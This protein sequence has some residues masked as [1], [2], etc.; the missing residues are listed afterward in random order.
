MLVVASFV[1]EL[2]KRMLVMG[3]LVA[4]F[5]GGSFGLLGAEQAGDGAC[6]GFE[7]C[8]EYGIV[9]EDVGCDPDQIGG[10]LCCEQAPCVEAYP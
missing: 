3:A 4:F 1:T 8:T 10:W 5:V 2:R 7:Y 6:W 9:C